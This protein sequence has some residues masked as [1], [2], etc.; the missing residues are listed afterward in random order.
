M[1]LVVIGNGFDIAHGLKSKY[2]DFME[3]LLTLEK[4]SEMIAI[5]LYT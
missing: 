5:G 3:Y 2:S 4:K 1:D